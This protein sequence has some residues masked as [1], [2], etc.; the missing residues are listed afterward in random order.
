MNE[1]LRQARI[2]KKLT[3]EALAEMLDVSRQTVAK[4][5]NGESMPDIM[6]CTQLAD[7]FDVE[8]DDIAA[9]FIPEKSAGF[10]GPKGKY[11]FG[12]CVIN[13]GRIVIP[14]DALQIFGLNDGDELLL[15]GDIK[16]GMALIPVKEVNDFVSQFDNAPVLEVKDN[17]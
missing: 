6:R 7:I 13:S 5:E 15:M 8:M 12:R 14:E 1:A 2:R 11:I 10:R 16:Q 9:M 4:W 3:Q 17:E